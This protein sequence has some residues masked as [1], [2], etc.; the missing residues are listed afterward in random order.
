[1][2]KVPPKAASGETVLSS[3]RGSLDSWRFTLTWAPAGFS[4][5]SSPR[6]PCSTHGATFA[7]TCPPTTTPPL[8]PTR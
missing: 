2:W 7:S 1:M 3:N 4:P 8:P 6:R 5:G